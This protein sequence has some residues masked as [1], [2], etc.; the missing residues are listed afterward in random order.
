M[1]F[2]RFVIILF[3]VFYL[4]YLLGSFV[5]KRKI[6]S[7]QKNFEDNQS[8]AKNK[9]KKEGDVS[10]NYKPDSKK[11]ISDKEGEYV[12]FEEID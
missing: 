11:N 4:L 2:L 8:Q 6:R 10:V 1:A 3:A 12:D 9:G 5:I 7:F